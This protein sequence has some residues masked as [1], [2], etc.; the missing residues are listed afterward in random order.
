MKLWEAIAIPRR[1]MPET[2]PL[3]QRAGTP[4][5]FARGDQQIVEG[6][7]GKTGQAGHDS[8]RAMAMLHEHLRP[9]GAMPADGLGPVR[10]TIFLD[11]GLAQGL[12]QALRPAGLFACGKQM[13]A[14][15]DGKGIP[16]ETMHGAEERCLVPVKMLDPEMAAGFLHEFQPAP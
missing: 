10:T 5:E 8:R 7:I 16:G 4:G 2:R 15:E 14:A 3:C 1:A 9:S 6:G 13:P 12:G 11:G